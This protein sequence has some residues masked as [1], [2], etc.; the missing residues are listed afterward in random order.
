ME[1][2]LK[3]DVEQKE[4]VKSSL[5]SP[6]AVLAGPGS[7]KTTVIS[8]RYAYLVEKKNIPP[9]SIAAVTFS[10]SMASEMKKRIR[11]ITTSE[12]RNISTIHAFCFRFLKSFA[13]DKRDKAEEWWVK[14]S[15]LEVLSSM[16]WSDADWRTVRWWIDR[17]KM[18]GVPQKDL[19]KLL[20]FFSLS[21]P[22]HYARKLS[23]AT[24]GFS[25]LQEKHGK[26]TFSDMINDT[27]QLLQRKEYLDQARDRYKYV[28]ID[29]AQDSPPITVDILTLISPEKVFVVGDP[30]QTLYRFTGADPEHNLFKFE[31]I[32][33]LQTNYRCPDYIVQSSNRLIVNNYDSSNDRFVKKMKSVSKVKGKV[34]VSFHDTPDAEADWVAKKIVEE[35]LH[36]GSVFVGARTN[37]QLPYIERAMYRHNIPYLV[38]GDVTFYNRTHIRHIIDYAKLASSPRT[39]N[40][41]F[42]TVYNIASM[43]MLGR[44]KSYTPYRWLGHQFLE[45]CHKINPASYFQ[46]CQ[47]LYK[48]PRY[49]A[50]VKDLVDFVSSLERDAHRST[51]YLLSR[52]IKECY[53]AYISS[54]RASN[55][56]DPSNADNILEDIAV[57]LDMAKDYPSLPDFLQF[58][59]KMQSERKTEKKK[60]NSVVISTI[61]KMKGLERPC[62]FG[63]GISEGLLPHKSVISPIVSPDG[64]QILNT[65]TIK[66][67]RCIAFVLVTRAKEKLYL[68]SVLSWQGKPLVPS[69][70]IQE[71]L[72]ADQ[73]STL[74]IPTP[75]VNR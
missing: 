32:V 2:K 21:Q 48:N 66:D 71:L 14:S 38:M 9:A 4:A 35:E 29:E 41:A 37:S 69:R 46:A 50:G 72:E 25:N 28:L 58:V 26:I 13:G 17:S 5:D 55:P 3:L 6:V 1:K 61:H 16:G 18:S 74:R 56:S 20:A 68:S 24:L 70:F 60:R 40:A 75:A 23:I 59:T 27:W 42:R 53:L 65:S 57:L 19:D 7:G 12:P 63:I 51:E 33:K 8:H 52:I 64:L 34:E 44:N 10:T 49:S 43:R 73:Y 62:V 31:D 47:K 15:T 67:E 22:D 11:S 30:D 45:D 39:A 54:T 36:P